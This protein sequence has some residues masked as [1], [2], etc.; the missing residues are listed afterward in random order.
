MRTALAPIALAAMVVA[1]VAGCGSALGL[2]RPPASLDPASP[3]LA[4]AGLAFDRSSLTVPADEPFVL[5]FENEEALPHNVSIYTDESLAE[6]R[7]EGVLFTGPGTRWYPV[8]AL[9]RGT[10]A[11]VCDLHPSMRGSLVAS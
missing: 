10:Y 5:V 9:S 1:G 11:F 4:A 2:D 8:P 7:F 6:R 3:T